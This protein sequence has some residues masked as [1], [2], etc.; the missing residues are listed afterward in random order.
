M[1]RIYY[2][3]NF[4][5]AE[6][7]LITDSSELHHLHGVLRLGKGS[8]VRIFDGQGKEA[9]GEI[10]FIGPRKAVINIFSIKEIVPKIP[11][12]ILACAVPKKTKFEMIIEKATELGVDEIIPLKTKRTEMSLTGDR[13][14]KKIKRYQIVA[15]NAAKQSGRLI[16]PKIHP[17]TEFS[18]A[19]EYLQ[20]Q[21]QMIIPSLS[22]KRQNLIQILQDIQ[23]PQSISFLIG[24]EGDFTE[25]E[26]KLAWNNG[27]HP[28]TLGNTILKVET[29][30]ISVMSCAQLFYHSPK[31]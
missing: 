21:S 6:Q 11:S 14:S 22:G 4:C 17:I 29:A 25:K 3:S 12:I 30:A 13:A 2:P 5:K 18:K 8:K 10:S 23:S 31:H 24:P 26:Y 1:H 9:A 16:V 19:I 28:V 15:I 27:A 20:G 7:V